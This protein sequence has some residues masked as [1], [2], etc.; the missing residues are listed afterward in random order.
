MGLF[1]YSTILLL[2]YYHLLLFTRF[3]LQRV[4]KWLSAIGR[5]VINIVEQN[6]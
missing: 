4:N 1:Y 3:H 5:K 2:L 6:V